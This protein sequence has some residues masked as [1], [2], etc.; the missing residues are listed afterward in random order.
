MAGGAAFKH[1]YTGVEMPAVDHLREPIA[2]LDTWL[3]AAEP[4]EE[5]VYHRGH[6]LPSGSPVG[7]HV[8]KLI[9]SG[10]VIT[11]Q[12]RREGGGGS[13]YLV[14]KRRNV[15]PLP[16]SAAQAGART[17]PRSDVE[18]DC[19]QLMA[20][21]RRL[22][23]RGLAC[24]TNRVLAQMAHLDISPDDVRYRLSQLAAAERIRID[25][26]PQGARIVTIVASGRRTG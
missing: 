26:P 7:Q 17:A 6:F 9:E 11:S 19:E 16:F 10:H 15:E 8:R 22:A 5:L 1:E 23:S 20:V 4:G 18:Q 12:R 2:A 21:L 14:I 24:P 13:D 25:E 3:R